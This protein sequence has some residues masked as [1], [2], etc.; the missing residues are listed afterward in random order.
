VLG[1][2]ATIVSTAMQLLGQPE[3]SIRVTV[4]PWLVL[5]HV[6]SNGAPMVG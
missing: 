6:I 5:S 4:G 1:A 3:S 2:P